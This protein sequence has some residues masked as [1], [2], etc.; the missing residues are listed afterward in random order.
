MDMNPSTSGLQPTANTQG[1]PA[2]ARRMTQ[3]SPLYRILQTA[4]PFDGPTPAQKEKLRRHVA[5]SVPP[6]PC[7]ELEQFLCGMFAQDDRLAAYF[8]PT[9]LYATADESSGLVRVLPFEVAL[10]AA[11]R[12]AAMPVLFPHER[13]LAALA[14]LAYPC[15]VFH[16]AD[17]S[18]RS[19]ASRGKGR[20]EDLALLRQVLLADPMRTLRA[21][22]SALA[23]T[24]E[25]ALGFGMSDECEPHQ[26]SRLV[27]SVRLA[28]ISIDQAWRA[29]PK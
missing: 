12:A 21:K 14:A 23:A 17:P 9:E 20:E 10:A 29:L 24:L 7:P 8:R 2:Y 4:L 3:G 19:L 25:A 26:V 13:R 6:M 28:T 15:A 1:W 27:S 22:N 18:L 5:R 11:R 16:A